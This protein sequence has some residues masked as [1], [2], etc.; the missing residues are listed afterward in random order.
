MPRLHCEPARLPCWLAH[1]HRWPAH[2]HRWPARLHRWPARLPSVVRGLALL[3]CLAAAAGT[4]ACAGRDPAPGQPARRNSAEAPPP[5]ATAPEF[6]LPDGHGRNHDLA[7]LMGPKG[8]VIVLYR[9]H[10]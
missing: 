10:W 3:A 7:A 6:S 1:L 8:L 4:S 5:F 9:G 2:L